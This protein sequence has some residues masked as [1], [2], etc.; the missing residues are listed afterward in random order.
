[1]ESAK[2]AR[3]ALVQRVALLGTSQSPV[4][5]DSAYLKDF[6]EALEN[7]LSTPQALSVLQTA[8]KDKALPPS[9]R[10]ALAEKM[11]SVLGLRLLEA[12]EK[13]AAG[14]GGSVPED[15]EA[16]IDALVSER[17]EAKKAKNYARA[18]EIRSGLL[19]KGIVLEDTSS[20]TIWKRK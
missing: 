10:L 7:D 13:P 18:D 4:P 15:S 19:E 17:T 20:G 12:A 9:E 8:I 16:Q 14:A 5:G 2:N 1:M 11:D 6:R 3:K